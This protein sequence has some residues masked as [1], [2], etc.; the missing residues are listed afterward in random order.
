MMNREK[1]ISS[2][3]LAPYLSRG[4]MREMKAFGAPFKL[5]RVQTNTEAEKEELTE[6]NVERKK[7]I[8]WNGRCNNNP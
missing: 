5:D 3:I 4:R 6:W 8:C 1:C 7:V 2:E